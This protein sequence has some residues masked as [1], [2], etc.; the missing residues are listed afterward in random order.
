MSD[1]ALVMPMAG[2]GSRFANEGESLPKPLIDLHGRPFFWWATESVRRQVP[3]R[4]LVYVVLDEHRRL[5]DIERRI[6]A[7]YPEAHIV[8]LSDVTSGAAETALVGIQALHTPGPV[9]VNDCDHAFICPAVAD[10]VT[11]LGRGLDGALMCF[12]SDSPSYS[13]AETHP[14]TGLVSHTVEKKVVSPFAIGGCYYIGDGRQFQDLYRDYV[15]SCPYQELFMSGIFNLMIERGGA[16]GKVEAH[17]HC[18]FG[19]PEEFR[20]VTSERFAPF[21]KWS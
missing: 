4:E 1:I 10:I 19:T 15:D 16:I 21:L 12:R 20:Q 2:R 18:S 7:L 11:Q 3:L 9:A 5:F 14:D 8:S 6:H 17:R 13:Y